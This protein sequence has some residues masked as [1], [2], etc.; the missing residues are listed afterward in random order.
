MQAD[1][2]TRAGL[3]KKGFLI[4]HRTWIIIGGIVLFLPPLAV[5]FQF[6][7]DSNFCGTWCPRMFFSWRKGTDIGQFL[8][9]F[10]RSYMGVALVAGVLLS[11]LL[12]G[13][14]W[15]SHLCP[16][17]GSM[18]AGSRL[19]P[20]FVKINFS[21]IPAPSFRYG[22]LLMYLL[23]P[24][25]GLGSL[26]CNYCNFGVVPRMFGATFLEADMAYFLRTAG[27]I[28]LGL[29]V[30]LG[31]MAKGGRAYCNLLCPI[32]ALDA[33][34]NRIGYKFGKRM[35]IDADKCN[36]CGACGKVCPAWAIEVREKASID[37]LSC[38]PCRACEES[39]HMEAIRYGKLKA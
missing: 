25:I 1:S 21:G 36:G 7:Q 33:L 13:R 24:A 30:V 32:G 8:F 6:T 2:T 26:C 18:E 15:C 4:T 22:Y 16:V 9:G 23:L 28:N 37:Q 27:L 17:G 34:S 11:T 12:L 39:C 31:F 38:M 20:R 29:I 35:N 19:V 10:L 5:L 14:Y 3:K